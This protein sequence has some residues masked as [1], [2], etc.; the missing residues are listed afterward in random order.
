MI[1]DDPKTAGQAIQ[2]ISR[3]FQENGIDNSRL[4]ARLLLGHVLKV[5]PERIFSHPEIPLSDVHRIALKK[6]VGRRLGREPIARILGTREFWS[7]NFKVDDSTLV[8]RP[9]SET[10]VEAVLTR[11][12]DRHS[13]LSILDLGTGSGCLL[14]ALLSELKSATGLGVDLSQQALGVARE[15]AITHGLQER[16]QFVH[17]NWFDELDRKSQRPFDLIISNPPYIAD[18]EIE[19]LEPDVAKYDPYAALSG[20]VDGLQA[21]RQLLPKVS[22]FIS[23]T[24]CV[25]VEIGQDQ[26]Q[27]VSEIGMAEGLIVEAICQDIA[28][29][30]R[31]LV[32][33]LQA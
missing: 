17:G 2:Q 31:V 1:S 16:V 20:G 18:A 22:G 10:L 33:R 26:A 19:T 14:L 24:G 23:K 32:F 7:L 4:D 9:D 30:D 21:Y 8:P 11:I 25:V 28:R 3:L 6:L 15:N 29:R 5:G 13:P 27:A 12:E